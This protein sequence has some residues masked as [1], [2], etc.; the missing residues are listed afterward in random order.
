VPTLAYNK[1]AN[2]DYELGQKYEAGLVLTGQE[3]KS[4]KTGHVSLKGAYVTVKSSGL[5]IPELHLINAHIPLY[6]HATKREGYDAY[7]S[8]KLLLKKKEIDYLVG[9][10]QEQG[11]TLVPIKIYTK[12]SLLKLEFG[13]GK[14]R[15]KFDKR[16]VIKKRESDRKM[17]T[18]LKSKNR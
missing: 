4:I 11:L 13:L 2:F 10:K 6:K 7:R 18:L 14:G 17:S 8:R 3:V 16:D 5:K 12:K 9:K 1:R 15:K